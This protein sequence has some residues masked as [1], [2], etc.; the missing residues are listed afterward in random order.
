MAVGI[1]LVMAQMFLQTQYFLLFF[2]FLF[3]LVKTDA[4]RNVSLAFLYYIYVIMFSFTASKV[5]MLCN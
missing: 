2:S 5:T 3:L 4:L 1:I